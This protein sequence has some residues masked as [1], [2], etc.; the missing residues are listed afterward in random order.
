MIRPLS[1]PRTRYESFAPCVSWAVAETAT[2][3][4]RV[5]ASAKVC[6]IRIGGSSVRVEVV[7]GHDLLDRFGPFDAD[8]LLIKAVIEVIQFVGVKTEERER[9]GVKVLDVEAV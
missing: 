4:N 6:M 5:P 7:S 9:R 3:A 1:P 8:K 2:A